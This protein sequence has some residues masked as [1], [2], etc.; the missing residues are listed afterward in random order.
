MTVEKCVHFIAKVIKYSQKVK[1]TH[2][3][4]YLKL[5]AGVNSCDMVDM[6]VRAM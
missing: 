2:K 1:A 3:K 4:Y 6:L 5:F